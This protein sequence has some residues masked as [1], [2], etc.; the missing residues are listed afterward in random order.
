MIFESTNDEIL[1]GSG[2]LGN[3]KSSRVFN[4]AINKLNL[5]MQAKE[6][7]YEKILVLEDDICFLKDLD[8]I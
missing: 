6:L 1:T 3:F 5:M 2:I 4:L 7:G 8:E